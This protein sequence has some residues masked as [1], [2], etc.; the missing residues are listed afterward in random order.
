[1]GFFLT[2]LYLVTAYLGPSTIFG[3]LAAAHIE[4][5]LAALVLFVSLPTLGGGESFLGK[6]PQSLALVGLALT[7]LVSVLMTGWAGGATQAFLLFIPNAF[8]YFLVCLHCDSKKKLQVLILMLLF[9][10]LFIIA[11]GYNDLRHGLIQSPY[12]FA[13]K[14]DAGEWFYRLK[15]LDFISDPN[16]FAQVL[17]CVTP[18]V[19]IFWKSKKMIRN[20]FFVVLPVCALLF[21][22]FLTHSRGS[23]L[24]ILA[25]T[26]VA[27]RRKV[28]TVVSLLMAGALFAAASALQFTGGREISADAGS[29]RMDAWAFGLQLLRAHPFI[30][31]GYG[32]FTEYYFITAHNSIV[33]CAAELGFIGLFFWSLFLFPTMRD[34]LALASPT[35]VSDG[36]LLVPAKE[37]F[38]M[39][40]EKA[41][42]VIDK[43]EVNRLGRLMVLSLT[44]FLVTSWFLSRA[45]SMTLFLLGGIVEVIYEMALR[46]QMVSARM[47]MARTLRYSVLF[48]FGLLVL[49][50]IVLRSGNLLR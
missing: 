39:G 13:Q 34:A 2:I 30:G 27:A 4:L 47:P 37:L 6:T 36:E 25:M 21:G 43:T 26:V 44:G 18:L 7:V 22:S 10:C 28:G 19:F 16:D 40:A 15:G 1:M 29:G 35:Q 45:Y 9:I 49:V 20:F 33:V 48:A 38:P 32:R 3:P 31:V 24:G 12:L 8:A 23:V 14:S 5:I 11:H 50:Y 42:D 41:V 46:R 17:V